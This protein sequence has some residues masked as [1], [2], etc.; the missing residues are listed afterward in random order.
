[1]I[2]P[3]QVTAQPN[4]A[5]DHEVAIAAEDYDDS[6]VASSSTSVTSSILEYRLENGRTYHG[7]KEGKYMMP[8]DDKEVERLDLQHNLFLHT[9]EGRLATAPPNEPGAKVGRVLDVGTGSGIWAMDFGDEH[10]EAEPEHTAVR[11][12]E[13]LIEATA[14]AG[15][16]YTYIPTLKPILMEAGFEYVTMQHFKWPTNPW[17]KDKKFKELGYWHNE[18]LL[19]GWEAI[20]M[21]PLTRALGWTK[22]EVQVLMAQNRKEF[23][24]RSIHAYHSIWTIYGRKPF[25][26][27]DDA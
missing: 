15:R 17:P 19:E 1:M 22:E 5:I 16:K 21:A 25:K 3:E 7:Y 9:F 11:T 13:L 8:N 14:K 24:D 2:A 26:T 6:A 4:T 27:D 20:C 23:N 18:N 10:P 12:G